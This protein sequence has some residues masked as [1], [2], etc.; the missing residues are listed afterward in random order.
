MSLECFYMKNLG[1]G[2]AWRGHL[3]CN[4]TT[5]RFES[6]ILHNFGLTLVGITSLAIAR[7]LEAV[8]GSSPPQSTTTRAH[9][10]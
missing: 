5:D 3:I 8:C 2:T 9:L 7:I 10:I 1:D 6:D 4:Q